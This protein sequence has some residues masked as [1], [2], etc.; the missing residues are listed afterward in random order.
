MSS[1]QELF[2]PPTGKLYRIVPG[3]DLP[4]LEFQQVAEQFS[5]MSNAWIYN[6]AFYFKEDGSFMGIYT[7]L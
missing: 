5:H 7:D 3:R 1:V 4:V 6:R 2:Q